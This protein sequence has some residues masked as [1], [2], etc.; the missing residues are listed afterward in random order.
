[1]DECCKRLALDREYPSD[2]TI[3]SIVSIDRISDEIRTSFGPESHEDLILN[4][5]KLQMLLQILRHKLE[6]WKDQVPDKSPSNQLQGSLPSNYTTVEELSHH[7]SE[8]ELHLIGIPTQSTPTL[9][10]TPVSSPNSI[11]QL[12]ILLSCFTAGTSFLTLVLDT[13]PS[14]YR[15]FSFLE[16]MRLPYVLLKICTL[17]IPNEHFIQIGW[18]V[19]LAQERARLDSYLEEL[20]NRFQSLTTFNPPLQPRPD[21]FA[22]IKVIMEKARHWYLKKTR[23]AINGESEESPLEVLRDPH[24]DQNAVER[25]EEAGMNQTQFGPQDPSDAGFASM[26]ELFGDLDDAF[27]SSNF[28]NSEMFSEM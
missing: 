7:F 2:L 4:S 10:G 20:C 1:M 13:P 15:L 26:P 25:E 5:P 16:W 8:M 17:C 24:E 11:S 9:R 21:F 3:R 12:N 28:F 19:S 6:Q 23:G 18:N 14:Q 22:S 27:W